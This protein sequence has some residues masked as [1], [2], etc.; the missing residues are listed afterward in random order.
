MRI[1][2]RKKAKE[3]RRVDE[4]KIGIALI[5]AILLVPEYLI[6]S[7]YYGPSIFNLDNFFYMNYGHVVLLGGMH[8]LPPDNGLGIKYF[9]IFGIAL[10]YNFFGSNL[11]SAA[12]FSFLV[13]CGAIFT[14]YLIG[15]RLFGVLGGVISAL[16]CAVSPLLIINTANVSEDP[17]MMLFASLSVLFYLMHRD[18]KDRG[19]HRHYIFLSGLVASIGIV[20]V[21]ETILIMLP[22]FA[23]LI[24][25]SV[26]MKHS[27]R[28]Y[29]QSMAYLLGGLLI[30]GVMTLLI[31]FAISGN[32]YNIVAV[33]LY[34][35][36][37]RAAL[38]YSV[39]RFYISLM[40]GSGLGYWVGGAYNIILRPYFLAST[41]LAL[42]FGAVLGRKALVPAAWII[43][44]L[45]GIMAV[46][47]SAYVVPNA[48]MTLIF[49]PAISLVIGGG[50][51]KLLSVNW[52]SAKMAQ[53]R[54]LG[55]AGALFAIFSVILIM[56][57]S[58]NAVAQESTVNNAVHVMMVSA[59]MAASGN[60]TEIYTGQDLFEIIN[61]YSG[62]AAKTSALYNTSCSNIYSK[63]PSGAYVMLEGANA[64]LCGLPIVYETGTLSLQNS[65]YGPTMIA[66]ME[67]WLPITVVRR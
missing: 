33:I 27:L 50:V 54:V 62:F 58:V 39:A 31:G 56:V 38:P 10:L 29:T 59:Y 19:A 65:T 9:T 18:A 20:V 15:R 5:F 28:E 34:Y 17:A 49:V 26:G 36:G 63:I 67:E 42:V 51:T 45:I 30:G 57:I 11:F 22:I 25:D 64:Q 6:F 52:R 48:R 4:G 53:K 14:V 23:L 44:A 16:A 40:I 8:A 37:Q 32:L 43:F 60:G 41:L 7:G 55:L 13:L 24:M 35:A 3:K 61:A 2:Q 47:D 66:D 21:P 1:R 12:L 46:S